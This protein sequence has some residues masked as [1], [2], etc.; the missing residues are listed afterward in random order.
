MS[1]VCEKTYKK[2]KYA[3]YNVITQGQTVKYSIDLE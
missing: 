2:V 1:F 3:A